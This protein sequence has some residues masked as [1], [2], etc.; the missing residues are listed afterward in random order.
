ML[1]AQW[2]ALT[3]LMLRVP[4]DAATGR[5]EQ[6]LEA[7]SGEPRAQAAIL[8]PLSM[9]YGYAGR[10]AD[11]RQAFARSRVMS[12]EFGAKLQWAMGATHAGGAIELIAGDF[13]AAERHLKVGDEVLQSMG[14]HGF[15]ATVL[16]QLAEAAYAQGH[17]YEAERLTEEAEACAVPD[18]IDSQAHWAGNQGKAAR[19]PRAVPHSQMARRAGTGATGDAD[20]CIR[21]HM[22][23]SPNR[24]V[25]ACRRHD[26]AADEPDRHQQRRYRR[27]AAQCL[28]TLVRVLAAGRGRAGFESLVR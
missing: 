1:A 14:E 22:W 11:A 20:L 5:I 8:M 21:M 18:D 17:F 27:G 16:T 15:R 23:N 4:V 7:A 19:A 3:F 13:A 26:Y 28:A 2:L 25:R 12:T 10:F 9:Q 24:H 6:L